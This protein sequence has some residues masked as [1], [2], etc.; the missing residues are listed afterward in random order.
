MA[1]EFFPKLLLFAGRRHAHR[2]G[3]ILPPSYGQARF[4]AEAGGS[5]V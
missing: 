5:G 2:V 3:T 4:A 1:S